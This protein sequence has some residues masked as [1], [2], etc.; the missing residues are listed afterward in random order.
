MWRCGPMPKDTWGWGGVVKVGD[1]A[2]GFYFA[3]FCGDHV[4]ICPGEEVVKSH[5]VAWYDNGLTLPSTR[6][7]HLTGRA[8]SSDGVPPSP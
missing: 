2:T 8:G 1:S 6:D 3:D 7:A 5:E 4:K